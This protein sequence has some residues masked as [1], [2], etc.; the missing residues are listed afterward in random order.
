MIVF[1][2]TY[3]QDKSDERQK[4]LDFTL[5]YNLANTTFD[6]IVLFVKNDFVQSGLSNPR[7]E[8][9]IT[10]DHLPTYFEFI[11]YCARLPPETI[12]ILANSDI[13]LTRDLVC[14]SSWNLKNKL[15]VIARREGFP[16]DSPNRPQP[17]YT[18]HYH[19]SDCWILVTPLISDA[20]YAPLSYIHLGKLHCET[21]FICYMQSLGYEICNASLSIDA[22]HIHAS[23]IRN[24]SLQDSPSEDWTV[25][26]A[27]MISGAYTTGLTPT[28]KAPTK[29]ALSLMAIEGT[30][31][32]AYRIWQSLLPPL[33]QHLPAY[34][35]VV[36]SQARIPEQIIN[37]IEAP[38]INTNLPVQTS[39]VLRNVCKENNV[40]F[41]VSSGDEI[42]AGVP[43]IIPIFDLKKEL[44]NVPPNQ[45]ALKIL[46]RSQ[47]KFAWGFSESI[48]N[49]ARTL[50][51]YSNSWSSYVLPLGKNDFFSQDDT[52]S[53]PLANL[54][55]NREYFIIV[56]ERH[57]FANIGNAELLFKALSHND[58]YKQYQIICVGGQIDLE[59]HLIPYPSAKDAVLT[60]PTDPL[61]RKLYNNAFAH[62]SLARIKG[63]ELSSIEAMQCGCPN[64]IVHYNNPWNKLWDNC[65]TTPI[66]NGEILQ[67]VINLL[68]DRNTT[69]AIKE[70]GYMHVKNLNWHDTAKRLAEFITETYSKL[71]NLNSG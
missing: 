37:T 34:T 53:T 28:S 69:D 63:N 51:D 71:H 30:D 11:N 9:V 22:Y 7:I 36:S 24:Y 61:L 41:F 14:L 6:K 19:S 66:L 32:S 17:P 39:L 29:I 55:I 33:I 35:H 16:P 26:A 47:T 10:A 58:L 62:V 13:C 65:I 23:N 40:E 49:R 5:Q 67:E 70:A 56:G 38:P 52:D 27:P 15:C 64:L 1:L 46:A 50:Y 54:G 59:K 42:P 20:D 48:I 8:Y 43:T 18:E 45:H 57:G 2:T 3:Y 4:E 60:H 21:R 31:I 12:V 25:Q 68:K 44:S